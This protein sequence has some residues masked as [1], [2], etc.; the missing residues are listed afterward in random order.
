MRNRLRHLLEAVTDLLGNRP[1]DLEPSI[2]VRVRNE[3]ES[4]LRWR[5]EESGLL[6]A[7]DWRVTPPAAPPCAGRRTVAGKLA[8]ALSCCFS[9]A[10][11]ARAQTPPVPLH[12]RHGQNPLSSGIGFRVTIVQEHYPLTGVANVTKRI[13][14][15][16]EGF[17]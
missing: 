9:S 4:F 17:V 6:K 2:R 3:L 12:Q 8:D 11:L 7:S 10:D 16:R 5:V 15:L 13:R 14:E 1:P